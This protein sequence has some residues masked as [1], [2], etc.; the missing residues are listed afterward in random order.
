MPIKQHQTISRPL[1]QNMRALGLLLPSL[2][3]VR[4]K[5]AKFVPSAI[6]LPFVR[7]AIE[8]FLLFHLTWKMCV[9]AMPSFNHEEIPSR[10][11]FLKIVT[12]N[13]KL[14]VVR[15]WFN[16]LNGN[17][18]RHASIIDLLLLHWRAVFTG[19]ILTRKVSQSKWREVY[20]SRKT[21]SC[22]HQL[23]ILKHGSMWQRCWDLPS[24][25]QPQSFRKSRTS[26]L[27]CDWQT[28]KSSTLNVQSHVDH[29]RSVTTLSSCCSTSC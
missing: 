11:N 25:I 18:T 9:H 1:S 19:Q 21:K 15:R 7:K 27:E 8:S 23:D 24:R 29:I 10:E 17:T 14:W 6:Y 4:E 16:K 13:Y 3:Q 26:L 22:K 5:R 2:C 28:S 20:K 12:L